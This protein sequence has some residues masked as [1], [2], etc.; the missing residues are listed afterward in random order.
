MKYLLELSTKADSKLL[1]KL[2]LL[3]ACAV[4]KDIIPGY[5][6]RL[7]TPQELAVKVS[8]FAALFSFF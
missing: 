3:S 6:I 2:A 7:P 8:E 5:R 4:F 1:R